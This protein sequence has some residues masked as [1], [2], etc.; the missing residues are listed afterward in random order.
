MAEKKRSLKEIDS[1]AESKGSV[2]KALWQFLKFFGVSLIS[3]LIQLVLVY[4]L[5]LLFDGLRA[6]LPVFLQGIFNPELIFDVGSSEFEKYVADGVVT[7]GYVLPFFLSC[8]IA[9]IYGF[10]QNRKTTFKSD[11]RT[12]NFIIYVV[13]LVALIL[14]TTWLRCLLYGALTNVGNDVLSDFARLIASLLAALVQLVILFPLE[15]FVLLKE[16]KQPE[17]KE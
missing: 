14:F 6:T 9:N 1:A 16:K 5:P 10:F 12:L 4:T 3:Y 17:E 2:R 7:W 15:K 13:V 11:A 8:L